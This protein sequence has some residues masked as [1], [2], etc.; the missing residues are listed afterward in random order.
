MPTPSA[1][2]G[3]SAALAAMLAAR[4]ASAA[5]TASPTTP[6]HAP[7][8]P[9]ALP[10]WRREEA[11]R[12]PGAA[13]AYGCAV[14]TFD[15]AARP[16]LRFEEDHDAVGHRVWDAAWV[17][18]K[19]LE[20]R[21]AEGQLG[22]G[23]RVLELGSGTGLV[24]LVAAALLPPHARVVLTDVPAVVPRL[25]RHVEGRPPGAGAQVRVAPL[26]WGNADHLA[27]ALEALGGPPDAVLASDM[28]APVKHAADFLATLG[29]LL[30]AP[31]QHLLL[32]AQDQ[33]EITPP[34]L[35]G[36]RARYVVQQLPPGALH[37][38]FSSSPR[39]GVFVVRHGG[40]GR[41]AGTSTPL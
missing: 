26:T 20:R 32:C 24:G 5:A 1:S 21:A 30:R 14:Y 33:R 9:P 6:A 22:L 40:A 31:H 35:E 11:W 38:D 27:A 37:P 10:A 28:A 7:A 18:A 16:P 29:G 39:H 36:C 25:Q 19:L 41:A 23:L 8:G 2:S 17:L 4:V 12:T 34:L 3:G 13:A 15:D